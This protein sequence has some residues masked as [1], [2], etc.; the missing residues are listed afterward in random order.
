[1]KLLVNDHELKRKLLLL[2][3]PKWKNA[4]NDGVIL[5]LLHPKP[6]LG[7]EE[8]SRN[9]RHGVRSRLEEAAQIFA[10]MQI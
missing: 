10:G 7:V 9:S 8:N 5:L 6:M 2:H 1:M 3:L 4:V